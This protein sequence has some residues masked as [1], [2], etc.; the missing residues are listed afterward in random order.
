MKKSFSR[1]TGLLLSAA[2]LLG[3]AGCTPEKTG[4]SGGSSSQGG[5][6]DSRYKVIDT[7]YDRLPRVVVSANVKDYGA[8]GDGETDDA[9][10]FQKALDDLN[11]E[12]GGGLYVPAGKYLLG[13]SL[14][15][16]TSVYLVGDWY[17]PDE[18][19]E[20][21]TEGTVLLCKANKGMPGESAFIQV[22][23]G[24]GLYGVT[25]YYPEQNPENPA[26]YPATISV[27]DNGGGYSS[28]RYVTLVNSYN[29]IAAGPNGNELHNISDVYMTPLNRGLFVG[30]TTDC[31]RISDFHIAAKYYALYDKSVTEEQ[32]AA[33]MKQRATG[34]VLQRSD[35]QKFNNVSIRD[36][37]T[38][39]Y[40]EKNMLADGPAVSFDG[41]FINL[42]IG[43]VVTG[44]NI[45]F[46]KANIQ[47][48]NLHIETDGSEGASCMTVLEDYNA[49]MFLMGGSMKNAA[50]PA[51]TIA[52]GAR[53]A[54]SI[55]E[56][57]FSQYQDVAISAEGSALSVTDCKFQNADKAVELKKGVS[58]ATLANNGIAGGAVKNSAGISVSY[59]AGDVRASDDWKVDVDLGKPSLVEKTDLFVATDEAFGAKA[60]GETDAT[61]AIQ[62][63]LDAAK[64]NG[65]GIVYLPAGTYNLKGKLTVPSGVELRGVSAG[66]HHTVSMGTVLLTTYGKGKENADAF[67]SIEEN[68]G[69]AGFLV[70]Y[71]EQHY[72]SSKKYPYTFRFL[73][74]NI[75]SLNVTIGN[76]WRGYDLSAA[77]TAGHYLEY[78]AGCCLKEI[79]NID[80]SSARGVIYNCHYNLHFYS[81]TASTGLP[82]SGKEYGETAMFNSLLPSLNN[83]LDACMRL[84]KTTDELIYDFFVYRSKV[85]IRMEDTDKGSFS[86]DIIMPGFD[87]TM[88][89]FSI[90]TKLTEDVRIFFGGMDGPTFG[91]INLKDSDHTLKLIGTGG[92]AYGY[93]PTL[94][95]DVTNGK[96]LMK[97]MRFRSSARTGTVVANTGAQIDLRSSLFFHVGEFNADRSDFIIAYKNDVADIL[98]RG[99]TI[100]AKNN[101]GVEH[102]GNTG[103]TE[104][105][106]VAWY[107]YNDQ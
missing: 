59:T 38:A 49:T 91:V 94:G 71:P 103:A 68:A 2:L 43:N 56:I 22:K 6:T 72:A 23:D 77:D 95:Y 42:D 11:K 67:I 8:K 89:A 18:Q 54:I 47:F 44:I 104:T 61:D 64:N 60:D 14:T 53:G 32:V 27:F 35:W 75:Y 100:D 3:L 9:V 30:M 79:I 33:G 99:G 88:T 92:S 63:A 50:G 90:Q 101:I 83:T 80:G 51:I 15:I 102:F 10:A 17:N 105:N 16:H 76:G 7:G 97:G 82:G 69:V 39:I 98:E 21:I 31:G 106:V 57:D 26:T 52:Q 45:K 25:V 24:A 40:I 107:E 70:W 41:G 20:K 34:M 85:G 12:G 65:G 58:A 46:N 1:M 73:G 81:R 36:V 86:G 37:N 78:N 5:E 84:G 13:K 28:I 62:K 87:A 74:K 48:S 4:S 66:P 93:L 96:V 29:A 19:P 55:S